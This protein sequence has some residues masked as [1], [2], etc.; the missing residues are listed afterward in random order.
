MTNLKNPRASVIVCN[1]LQ[2]KLTPPSANEVYCR[3]RGGEE[4]T[5]DREGVKGGKRE[6]P[7]DGK[8]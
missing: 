1:I 4:V 8:F 6:F 2:P 7:S 3:E 5:S